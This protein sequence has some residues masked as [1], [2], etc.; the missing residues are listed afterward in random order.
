MEA[1]TKTL[2]GDLHDIDPSFREDEAD[3]FTKSLLKENTEDELIDIS[4]AQEL[5]TSAAGRKLSVTQS[6]LT[7]L[8]A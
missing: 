3:R 5:N 6:D 4:L 1:F 2:T 7:I 8:F